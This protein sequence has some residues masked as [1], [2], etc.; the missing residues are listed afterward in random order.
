MILRKLRS[1]SSAAAAA[2]RKHISPERQRVTRPVRF[3]TPESELSMMLVVVR[4]VRSIGDSPSRPGCAGPATCSAEISSTASVPT[5]PLTQLPHQLLHRQFP[6]LQQ[7]H[8][9]H[10]RRPLLRQKLAQR[11]TTL[12]THNLILSSHGGSLPSFTGFG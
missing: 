2:Q 11:S 8:H 10:Q 4:H 9:R 6:R 7:F 1:V 3:S 12:A 5:A